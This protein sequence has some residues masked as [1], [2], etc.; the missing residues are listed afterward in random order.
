MPSHVT[1]LRT[2][3]SSRFLEQG[4]LPRGVVWGGRVPPGDSDNADE[5]PESPGTAQGW[6]H[7]QEPHS[8]AMHSALTVATGT[9][10]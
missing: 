5:K 1:N 10:R 6:F 3:L 2:V 9:M 8:L 7:P 4:L